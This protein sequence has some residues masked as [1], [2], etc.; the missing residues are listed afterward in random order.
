MD[1]YL[2]VHFIVIVYNVIL[3]LYHDFQLHLT[4]YL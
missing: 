4:I 1:K 3:D 2:L